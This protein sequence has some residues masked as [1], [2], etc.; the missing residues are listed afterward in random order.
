[1]ATPIN[2][3]VLSQKTEEIFGNAY[4]KFAA[5][6]DP[7]QA[8]PFRIWLLENPNSPLRFPG[9]IHLREHDY[10]HILLDQDVSLSGEAFVIGFTMGNDPSTRQYHVSIFKFAA[11]YLYPKGY[12]FSEENLFFFDCGFKFGQQTK[13]KYLNRFDYTSYLNCSI[14]V[15][16]KKLGI[17]IEGIQGF[18]KSLED[19]SIVNHPAP[20]T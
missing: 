7:P 8:T 19:A 17:D 6:G 4:A 11:K 13:T 2:E 12:N 1:M 20:T 9:R 10:L 5:E 16:Q 14:S 3:A 15:V 18:F